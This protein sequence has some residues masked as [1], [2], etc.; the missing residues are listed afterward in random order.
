MMFMLFTTV[1]YAYEGSGSDKSGDYVDG[2]LMLMYYDY[3]EDLPAPYKSTESGFVPGVAYTYTYNRPEKK[4]F[5]RG[6]GEFS[7]G[8][9]KYDGTTQSGVPVISTTDNIFTNI[10]VNFGIKMG[11]NEMVA[12]YSGLGFHYW[13]RGLGGAGSYS[14]DYT[15]FYFPTG[16]LVNLD[17]SDTTRVSIDACLRFMYMGRIKV[18]L[19]DLS[20]YFN[21]PT[22][23]LG[24]TIGIKLKAPIRFSLSDG[25]ALLIM[26]WFE[27]STIGKSN[28]FI[29]TYGGIPISYA[30]EPSSNTFQ[31]GVNLGIRYAL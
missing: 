13:N 28:L 14:E 2:S 1:A 26:P 27:Y 17:I 11:R 20:P 30:Y 3:K 8:S 18:N 5:M 19:S 25:L 10:E 31:Y 6:S 22:G 9:T 15:W 16:L 21:D 23:D 7:Y 29:I 4:L 12:I 24:N